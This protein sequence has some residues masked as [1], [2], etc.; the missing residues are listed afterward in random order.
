MKP[1][2]HFREA[3]LF[4]MQ[5][6]TLDFTFKNPKATE[7]SMCG[8]FALPDEAAVSGILDIDRWNWHWP[9]PR[10]NVAPTTRVPMVSRADDALPNG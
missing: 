8:R 6:M 7:K 5:I 2:S 1:A 4:A 3:G 10:Y 9:E